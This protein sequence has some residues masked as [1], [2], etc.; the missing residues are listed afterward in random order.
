MAQRIAARAGMPSRT[1]RHGHH[2]RQGARRREAVHRRSAVDL[3]R[4]PLP[5]PGRGVARDRARA[6]ARRPCGRRDLDA[7][8]SATNSRRGWGRR[9]RLYAT[10]SPPRPRSRRSSGFARRPHSATSLSRL[11]SPSNGSQRSRTRCAP[12]RRGGSP[13]ASPS[14]RDWAL[15]SRRKVRTVPPCS[16]A[17]RPTWSGTKGAGQWRSPPWPSSGSRAGEARHAVV[18]SCVRFRMA[19][20]YAALKLG[21]DPSWR[22]A[23][24]CGLGL[25]P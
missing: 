11:A 18:M 12:P 22:T 15:G 23:W 5:G 7:S 16:S 20:P 25:W 14:R 1:R 8:R 17:L 9:S 3:R 2:G 13:S 10:R 4:D 21:P 24:H 19:S 6:E